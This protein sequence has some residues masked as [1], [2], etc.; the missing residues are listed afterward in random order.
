MRLLISDV[1][2]RHGSPGT[3]SSVFLS[4]KGETKQLGL[5]I[6]VSVFLFEKHTLQVRRVISNK[7]G[8]YQFNGVIKG[9]EYFIISHHPT[10]QF[11]AVIQDNVVPK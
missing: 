8:E 3:K 4:I 2:S 5:P 6:S 10:K 11:N 7:D 9:R 1:K